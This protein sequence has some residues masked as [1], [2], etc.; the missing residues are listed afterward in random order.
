MN[1]IRLIYESLL[2]L[3]VV[4]TFFVSVYYRLKTL[5]LRVRLRKEGHIKSKNL[6]IETLVNTGFWVI[7]LLKYR[8]IG[9]LLHNKYARKCNTFLLLFIVSVIILL[10]TQEIL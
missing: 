9:S 2:S 10:F 8:G 7:P 1:N 3:F 5:H 6:F 4:L